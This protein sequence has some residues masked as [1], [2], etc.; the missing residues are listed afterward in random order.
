MGKVNKEKLYYLIII[1]WVWFYIWI[2]LYY[3]LI[4]LI[5]FTSTYKYDTGYKDIII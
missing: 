4:I 1:Y 5:D 3:V 2:I